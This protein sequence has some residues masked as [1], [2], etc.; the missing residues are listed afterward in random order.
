MN[1]NPGHIVEGG[2]RTIETTK[3]NLNSNFSIESAVAN[4]INMGE[5]VDID[6][7]VRTG[8][9]PYS[10]LW[11]DIPRPLILSSERMYTKI[12][13]AVTDQVLCSMYC[14]CVACARTP[15]YRPTKPNSTLDQL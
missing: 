10:I 9:G 8:R 15:C 4:V 1:M 12:I 11:T 7:L 2:R 13:D 3:H 14:V 6:A 5:H